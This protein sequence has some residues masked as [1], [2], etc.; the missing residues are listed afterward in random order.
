[1][2][3]LISVRTN[4]LYTK[5]GEEYIKLNELVLLVDEPSYKRTNDGEVIRERGVK[6]LRF[7]VTEKAFEDL[8]LF[9]TDLKN[10]GEGDLL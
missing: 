5:V 7:T 3:Q 1:M 9:L 8:I 10:A 2:N 4:I 6:E